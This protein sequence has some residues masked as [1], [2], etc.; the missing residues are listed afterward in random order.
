M[1][2][3][4]L[5]RVSLLAVALFGLVATT[6]SP[7]RATTAPERVP[8]DREAIALTAAE[9][10]AAGLEDC[11]TDY[12]WLWTPDEAVIGLGIE[13]ETPAE[14]IAAMLVEEAGLTRQ[15][16]LRAGLPVERGDPLTVATRVVF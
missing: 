12:G 1:M 7:A 6:T 13:Y 3:G 16:T 10:E 15:Y 8:L 14:E 2:R 11:G 4:R 9:V 5:S